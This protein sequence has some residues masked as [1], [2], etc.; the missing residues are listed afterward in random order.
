MDIVH[1][2]TTLPEELA[3]LKFDYL[4]AEALPKESITKSL[5]VHL[6]TNNKLGYIQKGDVISNPYLSFEELVMHV[7][8]ATFPSEEE[9]GEEDSLFLLIDEADG[10]FIGENMKLYGID[11][12]LFKY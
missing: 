2:V 3:F 9:L 11:W 10:P 5:L 8:T 6:I 1:K 7:W 12:L 4:K